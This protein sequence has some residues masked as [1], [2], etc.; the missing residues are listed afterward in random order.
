MA[1][2]KGWRLLPKLRCNTNRITG[3]VKAILVLHYAST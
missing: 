3:I 1:T 2:L